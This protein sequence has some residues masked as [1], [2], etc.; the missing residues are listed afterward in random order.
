MEVTGGHGVSC[1]FCGTHP[2]PTRDEE[3]RTFTV[4]ISKDLKMLF[5][6]RGRK[7]TSNDSV[8]QTM[9]H[10]NLFNVLFRNGWK[11]IYHPK[12]TNIRLVNFPKEVMLLL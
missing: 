9:R 8:L 3:S 12:F 10:R 7:N 1:E 2:D 6:R 5:K 11:A 4:L